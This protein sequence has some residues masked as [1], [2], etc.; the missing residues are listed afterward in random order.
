[1]SKFSSML[2]SLSL[3]LFPRRNPTSKPVS[4][5]QRLLNPPH[6]TTTVLYSNFSSQSK[7]PGLSRK[8]SFVPL[9]VIPRANNKKAK[10]VKRR[11]RERHTH[12]CAP[13]YLCF[14][15]FGTYR[16]EEWDGQSPPTETIFSS[17][18]E[19]SA[20]DTGSGGLSGAL[21]QSTHNASLESEQI[22]SY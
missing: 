1:M 2:C 7:R 12:T 14:L 15:L 20:M 9:Q 5:L 10:G 13:F 16:E 19:E 3:S 22:S 4:A 17:V 21:H 11:E 6:Y 8:A 18:V